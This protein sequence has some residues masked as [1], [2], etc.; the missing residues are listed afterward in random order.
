M[1]D[2]SRSGTARYCIS[3]LLPVRRNKKLER[4][5]VLE[6]DSFFR[7]IALL[8]LLT[9][10]IATFDSRDNRIA[11][12]ILLNE[13]PADRGAMALDGSP[14]VYFISESGNSSKWHIYFQGGGWCRSLSDCAARSKTRLGSSSFAQPTILLPADCHC[15][16]SGYFSTDPARNPLM[17]DGWNQ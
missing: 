3:A 6:M 10:A 16:L 8:L 5:P 1:H 11:R 7:S 4:A 12:R 2:Y 14:P 15:S 9:R 13:A 17:H